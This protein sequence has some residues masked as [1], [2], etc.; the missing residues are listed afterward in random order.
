MNYETHCEG[1]SVVLPAVQ[2]PLTMDGN[3]DKPDWQA[4]PAD[5]KPPVENDDDIYDDTQD[6]DTTQQDQRVML[7]RLPEYLMKK[8]N[9]NAGE[10]SG[11]ELGRVFIPQGSDAQK[12][13]VLLNSRNESLSRLPKRYDMTVTNPNVKNV[14]VLKEQDMKRKRTEKEGGGVSRAKKTSLTG[15]AVNDC[16]MTADPND[17]NYRYVL[18]Q[19]KLMELPNAERQTTL[20]ENT[21]GVGTNKYGVTLKQQKESWLRPTQRRQMARQASEGRATRVDRNELLDMLF[22]AFEL[23]PYW[24]MKQLKER[25]HQPDV[26]LRSVLE[27]IAVQNKRGPNA[28]KYGLK[29]E[30]KALQGSSVDNLVATAQ[31]GLGDDGNS[32]SDME[33]ENVELG[34]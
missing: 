21:S 15:H 33:M 30:Y 32:D 13:R 2:V 22:R 8:L 19:R 1:G 9:E 4:P 6:L 11:A 18:Q 14:F 34:R 26:H 12:F 31:T 28:G 7:V 3:F 23:Q 5:V 27:S 10:L 25:T 24:T 16:V 17:P 29:E 20:L